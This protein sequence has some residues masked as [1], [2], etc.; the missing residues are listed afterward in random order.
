MALHAK[1]NHYKISEIR[2]T[3][4]NEVAK[5][6]AIG[7]DFEDVIQMIIDKTPA[8]ISHVEGL[9]GTGFPAEVANRIF[10]GIHEQI[11]RLKN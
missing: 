9:L 2:R 8:V 1:N 10:S 5:D 6:N 7:A 11:A 4:W 3:H